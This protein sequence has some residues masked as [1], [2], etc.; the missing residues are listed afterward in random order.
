MI[1]KPI[2]QTLSV[3]HF[4]IAAIFVAGIACFSAA[5]Q[6]FKTVADGVEHAQVRREVAGKPVDIN[7]LRL[8]LR[9]VRLDVHHANDTAIG[10]ATTSS[11]ATKHRAIAAINAGFFRLDRSQFLG[12]AAGML[13]IDGKFLSEAA[14]DRIQLII[15]NGPSKTDVLFGRTALTQTVKIAKETFV[16]AGTNRELKKNEVVIYTPEFGPNTLTGAADT[17]EFTIIKGNIVTTNDGLGNTAIPRNG[18]VLSASGTMRQMLIDAA[19]QERYVALTNT[20]RELP[21]EF[22]KS[23]GRLDIVTGVP[24]LVKNGLVDITWEREKSSKAF[25]ET[26]HPRTAVARLKDGKFLM[27]TVDGRTEASAGIGLN[28]LAEYLISIGTIEA[29]NLD[30]GGS[31]TM[32]LKGRIVNHPSDKEGERKVS[33]AILV[34]PRG[35]K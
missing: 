18:Y 3:L 24:Q 31:T 19:K 22:E 4:S 17:V 25:V 13:M 11:I 26:R 29:M 35:R 2:H 32:Y 6:D 1:T 20:W 8:D 14:N 9:K 15:N 16:I 30:G 28:D 10:T 21:A 23:R 34:T 33:D 7:L 12:D 5:A 27:I